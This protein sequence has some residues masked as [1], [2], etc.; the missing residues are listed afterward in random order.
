MTKFNSSSTDELFSGGKNIA[1]SAVVLVSFSLVPAALALPVP[2]K[3]ETEPTGIA[4]SD[5]GISKVRA[6]KAVIRAALPKVATDRQS[7]RLS[8]D[9][10]RIE[11]DPRLAPQALDDVLAPWRGRELSFGEYEKAIHALATYLRENG[12]PGA[13][14]RMSRAILGHGQVMIAIEG[15]S[16]DKPAIASA[17]IKPKVD[18]KEFKITGASLASAEELQALLAD[19]QGKP[20]TAAEMEQ[21]A[22]RVAN[23]LRAKGYPLV[24]AFLP[25]QRVDGGVV[26][27]AVQEG[28]LDALSGREGVSI[29]SGGERVKPEVIEQ[30]IAQGAR[31]GEPLRMADLER[32]VLLASDLAG[33]KSVSSQIEPGSQTGTTQVKVAVEERNLLSASLWGDNYGNRYTGASRALSQFQLNSPLGFG[34]QISL[35]TI[36]SSSSQS[37]RVG[38]QVPLGYNGL[39]LGAAYTDMNSQLGGE[40]RTIDL[41]SVA[42]ISS[43]SLSY[44]LLRSAQQN[45]YVSGSYDRK[46]FV[47]DL[48]WGRENDRLL[49][50]GTLA[51][52]GDFLDGYGGQS[53]WSVAAA[54]G[55]NDLSA[56]PLYQSVDAAGAKTGGNYNKFNFQLSRLASIAGSDKWSWMVG[57]AGQL[58]SKNLDSAEK[59]QLGGPGGV[60]AYPVSEGIGDNGWLLNAEVR[61]RLPD[62]AKSE[63]HLFSFFDAGGINQYAKPWVDPNRPDATLHNAYVLKGAGVGMSM[64]FRDAGSVKLMWARKIGSNPNPTTTN[65]DSDGTSHNSRIWIVGNIL[66]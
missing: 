14:V 3:P 47:T 51:A 6:G 63:T 2:G 8:L 35:N 4:L 18:V 58:A 17:E 1:R 38:L 30:F 33:V 28:R 54:H 19:Y 21:A 53:R 36:N 27:I 31:A 65:T 60:R 61:Y 50:V 39:K 24:Q 15:L 64:N 55:N 62:V 46:R 10:F 43:L 12:H 66:F 20:L 34:E 56:H 41:N 45:I 37:V 42:K 11:G 59:F 40:M 26:T 5:T 49:N 57:L 13:Q 7:L 23:H 25:P 29:K 32:G 48:T 9:G 44:P 22:Q 52:Y 16:A